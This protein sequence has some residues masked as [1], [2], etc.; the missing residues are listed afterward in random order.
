MPLI[1]F[2]YTHNSSTAESELRK[3]K[4]TTPLEAQR[5]LQKEPVTLQAVCTADP[6]P[7]VSWLLNGVELQPSAT[8]ITSADAKDL[9]HGLKECTFTLAIPTGGLRFCFI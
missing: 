6:Q 2:L 3:P 1:F 8:I 7:H 9:D 4:F 5:V